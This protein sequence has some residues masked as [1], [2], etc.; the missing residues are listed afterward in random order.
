MWVRMNRTRKNDVEPL[1]HPDEAPFCRQ[2]REHQPSVAMYKMRLS[3]MIEGNRDNEQKNIKHD[4]LKLVW[5][6]VWA[7]RKA[8]IYEHEL[9]SKLKAL[10]L[11]ECKS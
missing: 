4:L 9:A 10:N 2:C 1:R 3:S 5:A 11:E 6:N 8:K 7:I